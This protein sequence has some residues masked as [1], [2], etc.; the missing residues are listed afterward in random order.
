[1]T[2]IIPAALALACLIALSSAL[3][4]A[5]NQNVSP[6]TEPNAPR[7]L[8]GKPY[9]RHSQDCPPPCWTLSVT[10]RNDSEVN[11][12]ADA[13]PNALAEPNYA[14][15][16]QALA[17]NEGWTPRM[18]TK[19]R[20]QLPLPLVLNA[21]PEFVPARLRLIKSKRPLRY[22]PCPDDAPSSSHPKN[23]DDPVQPPV[24][25][26]PKG[27]TESRE[28]SV[29]VGRSKR[30]YDRGEWKSRLFEEY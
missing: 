4:S 22:S 6:Q 16:Y 10:D 27:K 8:L 11:A 23:E 20:V 30:L 15:A 28:A 2:K 24:V 12:N 25:S 19:P 9:R 18:D 17:G 1:M 21:S 14:S 3:P 5:P 13:D 29:L 7:T 26:G